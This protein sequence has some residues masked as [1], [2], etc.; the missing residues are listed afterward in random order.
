MLE[1][2]RV[3][4]VTSPCLM[5]S[6]GQKGYSTQT[7]SPRLSK[8]LMRT[9]QAMRTLATPIRCFM[10]HLPLKMP[11]RGCVSLLLLDRGQGNRYKLP[12]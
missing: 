8:G 11:W 1:R 4:L 2:D 9:I 12:N 6:L 3:R 5:L 7:T 10:H